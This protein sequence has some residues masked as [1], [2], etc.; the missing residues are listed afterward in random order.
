M[1]SGDDLTIVLFLVGTAITVA[2]TAM[3]A[4]GW[5]HPVLI[6]GLFSLAAFCAIAGLGW[7]LLK[8]ASPAVTTIMNQIATNPV[9]WFVVLMVA[10]GAALLPPRRRDT[11]IAPLEQK[12]LSAASVSAPVSAP[13]PAH[14]RAPAPTPKPQ[15]QKVFVN[16]SP[17]YLLD[18][19]NDRTTLQGDA[20]AAAY[21]GKWITATFKV[22]DIGQPHPSIISIQSVEREFFD[23]GGLRWISASFNTESSEEVLLVQ[24]DATITVRGKI[25]SVDKI[26]VTID[27]CELVTIS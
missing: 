2:G 23:P 10:V 27:N 11:A 6:S 4:A 22:Y 13:I 17:S 7:P 9:A 16:V 25:S 19:Y 12:G 21:I 14:T 5:R 1:L 26:R 20:L 3:S 15:P 18:L 24:K 8:T